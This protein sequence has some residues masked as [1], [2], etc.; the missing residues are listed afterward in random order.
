MQLKEHNNIKKTISKCLLARCSSTCD[1]IILMYNA[2]QVNQST[3][4]SA[5]KF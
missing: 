2:N 4:Q 5:D 3:F 1:I